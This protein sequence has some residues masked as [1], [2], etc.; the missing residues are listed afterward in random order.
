MSFAG[1]TLIVV[2]VALVALRAISVFAEGGRWWKNSMQQG[3]L[4]EAR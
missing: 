3:V 4:S 1:K 2:G